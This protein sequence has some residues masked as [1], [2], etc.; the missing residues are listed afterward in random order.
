MQ[1]PHPFLKWAG[2]KRQLLPEI[3]AHVPKWYQTYREPFLGGGALFFELRPVRAVLSDWNAELVTTFIAVRDDVERVISR[4][5]LYEKSHSR[6]FY[7]ELRRMPF[8]P[9]RTS[10]SVAARMIYL[11]RTCFNGL[12]RV[13]ADGVF[14]VPMGKFQTPPTICDAEN[15]RACSEALRYVEI[16]HWDFQY[17]LRQAE[18][19]DFVYCDPPYLPSS[20][21]ANFTSYTG[22]KFGIEDHEALAWSA[23]AAKRRGVHVVLSSAGNEASRRIYRD[24]ELRTVDGRRAINSQADGRGAV[25]ELLC[26]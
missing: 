15:L 11:N 13:N 17:A 4:L 1:A 21:T 22:D 2:G 18:R 16:K 14:N 7:E 26:T 20:D 8:R 10:E 25:K 5:Q 24:F 12:Y 3:R 6:R 9:E 23:S 19:G